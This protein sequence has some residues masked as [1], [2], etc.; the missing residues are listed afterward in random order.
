MVQVIPEDMDFVT[1][2]EPGGPDVLELARTEV[3]SP[4]PDEVLIHVAYA[5]VNRPDCIQ[6]AG[7]YPAPPGASRRALR[8]TVQLRWHLVGRD[9]FVSHV[10]F[11]I[12]APHR[13]NIAGVPFI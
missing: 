11:G 4:G 9:I 3:P 12:V 8:A 6:R 2:A 10:G 1:F 13:L 7:H 5:G